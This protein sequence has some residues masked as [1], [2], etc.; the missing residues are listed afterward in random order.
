MWFAEPGK[1]ATRCTHL[2]VLTH[3]RIPYRQLVSAEGGWAVKKKTNGRVLMLPAMI[4]SPGEQG[5]SGL[6]AWAWP[7]AEI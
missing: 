5:L 4:A 2:P 3:L 1:T 7:R 6:R